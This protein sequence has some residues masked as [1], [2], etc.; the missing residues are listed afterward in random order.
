VTITDASGCTESLPVV[1][2]SIGGPTITSS[3]T[4]ISCNGANNGTGTASASGGS[5]PYTYL[6]DDPGAQTTST[7]VALAA[8]T[9]NVS[10]SDTSGC[11]SIGTITITEP[12]ALGL[13]LISS[14]AACGISDG[15]AT[16]TVSGGTGNY[17]YS[18][19]P[20]GGVSSIAAGLAA[21]TYTLLVVDSAGC[22][23]S[24]SVIIAN[25]GGPVS[26]ISNT[27]DASC[28]SVDDGTATV[29]VVGGTLPMTYSWSPN[30]GTD[31]TAVGLGPGTYTITVTDAGGC[32]T[33]SSVL[34]NSP[35]DILLALNSSMISCAGNTDGSAVVSAAGGTGAYTYL[36][37]PTGD[38]GLSITNLGAGSYSVIVTDA[39]GCSKSDSVNLTEPTP[40]V[41]SLSSLPAV[42][43]VSDGS[44]I[45]SAS[46]GT[47]TYSYAWWPSGS[48]NDTASGIAVGVYTVTVTDG[49]NCSVVDSVIVNNSGSQTASLLSSAIPLL[50]PMHGTPLLLNPM[51]KQQ[52]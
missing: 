28:F 15:V 41:L 45:V 42:C 44:A 52:A 21:G 43:G 13:S 37:S 47:G 30:G 5:P 40:I 29:T 8:G 6:W 34:I 9:F 51:H 3:S 4:N 32:I 12:P 22:T 7:A 24:D 20:T 1:I 23:I 2:N 38:T 19:S 31:T 50:T 25:S 14:P 48:T 17:T 27:T 11:I 18:W 49:S 46:G 16:A 33:T 39:N 36:W 26:G 10:V 35:P